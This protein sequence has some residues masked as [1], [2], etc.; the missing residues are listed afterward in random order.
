M[1]KFFR[2]LLPGIIATL[3]VQYLIIPQLNPLFGD[4]L[5]QADGQ[6]IIDGITTGN[7]SIMDHEV[8]K[9]SPIGSQNELYFIPQ[10]DYALNANI[11]IRLEPFSLCEFNGSGIWIYKEVRSP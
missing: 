10:R 1:L 5:E 11:S 2:S 8:I 3:A 4:Q 6:Q 7:A 9:F